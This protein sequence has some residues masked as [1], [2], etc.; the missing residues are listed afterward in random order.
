MGMRHPVE[1]SI[2][3]RKLRFIKGL[4]A[5]RVVYQGYHPKL[6]SVTVSLCLDKSQGNEQ[7]LLPKARSRLPVKSSL[8]PK[9]KHPPV[10]GGQKGKR[11][12]KWRIILGRFS[13]STFQIELDPNEHIWIKASKDERIRVESEG[14][15]V[16][17]VQGE[18]VDLETVAFFPPPPQ[19]WTL[20]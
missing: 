16:Q 4:V 7:A 17:G 10:E 13:S 11:G 18:K 5:E 6:D 14:E 20:R 8:L 12:K 19:Q 15:K 3:L 1:G 2:T 9:L